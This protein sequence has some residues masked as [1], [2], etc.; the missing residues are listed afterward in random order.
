MTIERTSKY[1]IRKSNP[2]NSA[3]YNFQEDLKI[4]KELNH[5]LADSIDM[6]K[7]DAFR[8]IKSKIS[9]LDKETK[10]EL[11]EILKKVHSVARKKAA[12][13]TDTF[14]IEIEITTTTEKSAKTLVEIVT[15]SF[16]IPNSLLRFIRDMGLVYLVAEYEHFLRKT[17]AT[18]FT[19][20]PEILSTC[21]KSLTFEKLIKFE[22]LD[23]VKEELVEKEASEITNKD[24]EEIKKYFQEKLNINLSEYGNWENFT[25]RFYRRNIL[26]HNSGMPNDQYRRKTGYTGKN[27]RLSVNKE[28]LDDSIGIFEN[29]A[30]NIAKSLR[31]K[32]KT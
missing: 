28:Y 6:M 26:I 2:Y 16:M 9:K 5:K 27:E 19:K 11:T 22:S 15:D 3:L 31:D 18:T 23:A 7:V 20:K 12:H 30:K 29:M 13:P 25:E 17:I 1:K 4:L 24:V 8:D 32:Y 21:K 14:E 10:N